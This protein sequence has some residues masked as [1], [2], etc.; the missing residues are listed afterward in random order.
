MREPLYNSAD[1]PVEEQ[2]LSWLNLYNFDNEVRSIYRVYSA[3]I[4]F[5]TVLFIRRIIPNL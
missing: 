4:I 3:V 5:I 1:L 2:L